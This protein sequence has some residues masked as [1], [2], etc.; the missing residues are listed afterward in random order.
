MLVRF[1]KSS[2]KKW[3]TV[4]VAYYLQVTSLASATPG[5]A[6]ARFSCSCHMGMVMQVLCENYNIAIG[7][8]CCLLSI[9]CYH[10]NLVP[11]PSYLPTYLHCTY[12]PTLYLLTYVPTYLPTYLPIP[13]D[14]PTYLYLLTQFLR[15]LPV[16]YEILFGMG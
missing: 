8:P 15:E 13:T 16:L 11:P 9:L 5:V 3:I 10:K 2:R 1:Q 4:N 12:L 14:P 6:Y 7:C